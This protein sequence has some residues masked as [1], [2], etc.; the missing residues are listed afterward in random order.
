MYFGGGGGGGG[1]GRV[2]LMQVLFETFLILRRIQGAM[3]I[4]VD[5]SSCK[6]I[7]ILVRL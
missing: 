6:V 4:N 7:V 1:G 5:T 2:F 3:V